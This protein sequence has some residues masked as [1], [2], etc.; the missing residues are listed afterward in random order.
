M[1]QHSNTGQQRREDESNPASGGETEKKVPSMGGSLSTSLSRRGG[2][3]L[4]SLLAEEEIATGCAVAHRGEVMIHS[5]FF[6]R[7][8]VVGSKNSKIL[9]GRARDKTTS[10]HQD[11]R[12]HEQYCTV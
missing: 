9:L 5:L 3:P 8:F 10:E 1:I 2:Q 12:R 6:F 7:L 4:L 11:E